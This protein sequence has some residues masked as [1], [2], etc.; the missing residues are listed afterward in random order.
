MVNGGAGELGVLELN[1]FSNASID[2][3]SY[4]TSAHAAETYQAKLTAGDFVD[5]TDNTITTTYSAGTGIT[6]CSDVKISAE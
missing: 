2:L 6:I 4:E 3:S 5:I 1:P